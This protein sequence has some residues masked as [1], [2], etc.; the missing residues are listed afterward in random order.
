[1]KRFSLK[2]TLT[3]TILAA[4][5]ALPL[6]SVAAE[7]SHGSHNHGAA[8]SSTGEP[9]P[10]VEEMRLLDK[11]YKEIVSAVILGDGGRVIG[12]I[13]FMHGAMEKTQEGVHAGHVTLPKN[14][15][16]M[17]EF[18][19]LDKDFHL[20]LETLAKAAEANDQKKMAS[21]TH[22]LMDGCLTCHKQFRK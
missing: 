20:D 19:K 6:A 11:V 8:S 15:D 1:M 7:H 17:Q 12:A 3:G 10:L 16:K 22:K 21:L 5:L 13:E 18:E 9:N 14:A 2:R 4:I